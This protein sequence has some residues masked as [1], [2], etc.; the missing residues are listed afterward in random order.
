MSA[1]LSVSMYVQVH[2]HA[3]SVCTGVVWFAGLSS[4]G[5]RSQQRALSPVVW[6]RTA[7]QAHGMSQILPARLT[8]VDGTARSFGYNQWSARWRGHPTLVVSRLRRT[9]NQQ[10]SRDAYGNSISA[11]TIERCSP[12]WPPPGRQGLSRRLSN[13]P[14]TRIE[15]AHM[16]NRSERMQAR[17]CRSHFLD[18]PCSPPVDASLSGSYYAR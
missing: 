6:L 8:R 15:V 14:Q 16:T 2:A 9:A 11:T 17:P 18:R 12:S 5:D 10:V 3:R 7:W 13:G 1:C 4:W